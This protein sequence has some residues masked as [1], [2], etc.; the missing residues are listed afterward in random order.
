VCPIRVVID[1]ALGT[2]KARL[3]VGVSAVEAGS[4]L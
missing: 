3:L 4:W 2:L 1:V